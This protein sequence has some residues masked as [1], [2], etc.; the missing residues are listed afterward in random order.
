MDIL[1]EPPKVRSGVEVGCLADKNAEYK[2]SFLTTQSCQSSGSLYIV[3]ILH[4]LITLPGISPVQ[5]A[6]YSLLHLLFK[7]MGNTHSK[8]GISLSSTPAPQNYF[9]SAIAGIRR[10]YLEPVI[11][12][13]VPCS[14]IPFSF[15]RSAPYVP[16]VLVTPP[17]RWA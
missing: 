17:S 13:S 3:V 15:P 2:I 11:T 10:W 4:S 6:C 5:L 14:K 7:I 8:N 9:N 16:L 12:N 1:F